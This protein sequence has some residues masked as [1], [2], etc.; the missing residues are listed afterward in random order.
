VNNQL[1]HLICPS[2]G[3]DP[4]IFLAKGGEII[5][6]ERCIP[7]EGINTTGRKGIVLDGV[8]VELNPKADTCRSIVGNE[9]AAAF[10]TLRKH[11]ASLEGQK[12]E[13]SFRQVVDVDPK[14]LDAL[15]E[16][17]KALGC[18]PSFNMYNSKATIGVDPK[19]FTKRSAGGHIHIGLPQYSEVYKNR[20]RLVVLMDI[21]VG[22]TAVL[23]DR[24]PRNAERRQTYGRAGEYRLPQ[25]G[26]EY[27]TLS[28]FWLRSYPLLSGV[29]GT[30]RLAVNVLANSVVEDSM[31]HIF[32]KA[33]EKLLEMV[34]VEAVIKAIN[35]NDVALAKQNYAKVRDYLSVHTKNWSRDDGGLCARY[36]DA[37]DYFVSKID[38]DGLDYWFPTD[39]MT[40]WCDEFTVS[41][42]HG[43]LQNGLQGG[44]EWFME[45]VDLER[46]TGVHKHI[47]AKNADAEKRS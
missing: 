8:Q 31:S 24:D 14:E 10:R 13:V 34:D 25:H 42:D 28:N 38:S 30:T 18:A 9:I 17:S 1:C 36:L 11:L 35:T 40:Y 3:C 4:E 23:I 27:R 41:M 6:A 2:L 29:M 21:L 46:T 44:F 47:S 16:K 7:E 19:T 12:I 43:R 45:Q 33:E 22:N 32:K 37:F 20:E 15:S 39:P 5:G 26:L